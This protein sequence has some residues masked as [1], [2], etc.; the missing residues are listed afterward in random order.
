MGSI[1]DWKPEIY[2]PEDVE[3]PYFVQDTPVAR[4]E[5]AQEYT[6]VN[7]MD[8]GMWMGWKKIVPIYYITGMW[9]VHQ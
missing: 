2:K 8:Q 1:P 5:L 6:S 4:M 3:V 7:R 9:Q